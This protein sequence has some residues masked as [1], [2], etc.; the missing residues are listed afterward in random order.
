[1][2]MINSVIQNHIILF[3]N[4]KLMAVFLIALAIGLMSVFKVKFSS[5]AG[6]SL[7]DFDNL[8]QKDNSVGT[9]FLYAAVTTLLIS[10]PFTAAALRIFQTVFFQY[11]YLWALVPII[12]V[13]AAALANLL[14]NSA[15]I[16]AAPFKK[17]LFIICAVALAGIIFVLGNKPA[18]SDKTDPIAK[19]KDYQK[20]IPVMEYLEAESLNHVNQEL[21]ILAPEG[22]TEYVHIYGSHVVTLFGKDLWDG[23][24]TPYNYTLYSD[25]IMTLHNWS[26][27]WDVYGTPYAIDFYTPVYAFEYPPETGLDPHVIGSPGY[28]QLAR[29]MGID[30]IVFAARANKDMTII[31]HF[32][33]VNGLTR[34]TIPC[35]ETLEYYVYMLN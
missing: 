2:A 34:I 28:V 8:H 10:V 24:L 26:N 1:M 23:Y 19:N 7:F 16:K 29:D 21:C 9:M 11:E 17:I 35:D 25:D 3:E 27:L 20:S 30:A 15:N 4:N 5:S 13:I 18:G 22:L 31:E 14:V 6:T 33:T 32:E 12:P